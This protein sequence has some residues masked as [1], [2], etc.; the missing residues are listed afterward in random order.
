MVHV[1]VHHKVADYAKWK[2]AFDSYLNKRMGAGETGFRVLQSV[3]DPRDVTVLTDWES[4]E[5]ARRFMSSSDLRSAMQNAGVVGEPEVHF[6]QDAGTV[7][8]TSAD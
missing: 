7:R 6:L 1:L 2:Q 8:R 5:H 3:E 4:A